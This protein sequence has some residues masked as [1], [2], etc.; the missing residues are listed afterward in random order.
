VGERQYRLKKMGNKLP[1]VYAIQAAIS[2]WDNCQ[3]YTF[4]LKAY[5]GK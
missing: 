2:E 5:S 3:H 4:I 1:M